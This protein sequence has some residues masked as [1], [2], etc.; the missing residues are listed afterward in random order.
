MATHSDGTSNIDFTIE[1]KRLEA[2]A[3]VASDVSRR[4]A[5]IQVGHAEHRIS[6]REVF[7]ALAFIAV[8]LIL[9]AYFRYQMTLRDLQRQEA[10]AQ[11]KASIVQLQG[12]VNSLQASLA[13]D[14]KVMQDLINRLIKLGVDPKTLPKLPPAALPS[15][16][17]G[18]APGG[19]V[20]ATPSSQ[21]S[22]PGAVVP[23][24]STSSDGRPNPTPSAPASSRPPNPTPAPTPRPTPVPTRPSLPIPLP[25][26]TPTGKPPLS[27][28]PIVIPPI[29]LGTIRLG[30]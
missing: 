28:G 22:V 10:R 15:P 25:L 12:E 3:L 11:N 20:T 8:I 13:A 16:A 29:V 5:R 4:E 9:T 1:R 24:S 21:T 2:S 6:R 30:G 26:P 7:L 27:L 17:P 18:G 19:G 23:V 14:R